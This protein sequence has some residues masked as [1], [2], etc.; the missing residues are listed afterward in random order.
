MNL[1]TKLL[2][3]P[4]TANP[5]DYNSKVLLLGS[6]FSEHIGDKFGYFKF[7]HLQNPFGILFHPLA[8]E[9]LISK[10]SAEKRFTKN[11]VFQHNEQWHS[12][13]AHSRLSHTSAEKLVEI[14]NVQIE[15]T[16]QYITAATHI[17][18]TLG[19]A[20][21]Y[22]LKATQQTVANCHKLPQNDFDKHLLSVDAIS[23]AL[24]RIS[25]TIYSHNKKVSLIFTIS[26]VRHLKDGFVENTQ[27]K[28]H[29]ITAVQQVL[30][31]KDKGRPVSFYFPSYELM[32]DEL[33]DYRFY[34][35][36]MIHPNS[37]A[38]DYIWERFNEQWISKDTQAV[39]EDVQSIQKGLAHRPF[40]PKSEAHQTFLQNLKGKQEAL[41]TRFP[42]LGF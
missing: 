37:T 15:Q 10:A 35:A 23:E 13:D 22:K 5:I 29:L 18:I 32:M 7:Q 19:T 3:Q 11:D 36:D 40:N 28:A 8:I 26:P 31:T 6:C 24:E 42:H 34:A 30:R 25:E 2:L 9:R 21:A 4:S 14:L 38:I 12:F 1:Q 39:M 33:R 16:H 41:R 27:S 17:I 20:W